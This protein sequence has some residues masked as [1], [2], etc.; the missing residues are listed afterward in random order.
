MKKLYID[1]SNLIHRSHWVSKNSKVSSVY[2]FL[3]SIKKYVN[4]F[5]TTDIYI[6]WDSRRDRDS[7]N[8]RREILGE[9]YKGNRDKEKSAEAFKN[10]DHID[11]ITSSLGIKNLYPNTLE[12]DDIIAW[13]SNMRYKNE[14]AVIISTDKDMLQLISENVHVYNPMKDEHIDI[15]NFNDIVGIEREL[16]VSYKA[17]MGDKSDHISGIPGAGPKRSAVIA[18]D[19]DNKLLKEHEELYDRNI[20]LMD[21]N[22]S[23]KVNTNEVEYLESHLDTINKT[24]S[25]DIPAFENGAKYFNMVNIINNI[26]EWKAMFDKKGSESTMRNLITS[27]DFAKGYE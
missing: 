13:L 14:K 22:Y 3:T 5:Q 2:I 6:A 20:K 16:F 12:A 1:G 10:V 21:L 8:H 27:L 19:L 15:H 7:V 25:V 4:L 18:R 26:H 11:R 23:L 17:I 24:V 9:E